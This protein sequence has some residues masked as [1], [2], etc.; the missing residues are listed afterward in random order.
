MERDL[1]A[2]HCPPF[3]KQ[4]N[5]NQDAAKSAYTQ[6]LSDHSKLVVG[7]SGNNT[8]GL[9]RDS[10]SEAAA[11]V[12]NYDFGKKVIDI[13]VLPKFLLLMRGAVIG[14]HFRV[15]NYHAGILSGSVL[16]IGQFGVFFKI[17]VPIKKHSIGLV[18]CRHRVIRMWARRLQKERSIVIE[19]LQILESWPEQVR[20]V[21]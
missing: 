11:Y 10:K 2:S 21:A 9:L 17:T 12:T 5:P 14:E 20:S 4:G 6:V 16:E 1:I 15:V 8:D 3:N 19:K 7:P 13:V 18:R